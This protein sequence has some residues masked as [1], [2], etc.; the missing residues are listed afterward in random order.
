MG[1]VY[2][3]YNSLWIKYKDGEGEWKY[4]PSGLKRGQEREA[5]AALARI[6]ELVT[7]GVKVKV[8]GP[9]TVRRWAAI[10]LEHQ[11]KRDVQTAGDCE[12]RLRDHILP[13]IGHMRVDKVR[14]DDIAAIVETLKTKRK[15]R[16]KEDEKLAP[17]TVRNIY[18][19]AHALFKHAVRKELITSNP[20]KLEPDELPPKRD[21]YPEWRSTAIFTRSEVE[22]LLSV[23]SIPWWRRVFYALLFL[24][25]MRFGEAA[26]RRWRHYVADTAPL[27]RL[28][29]CTS[30]QSKK[31][32]EKLPKTEQTR[33]VPVHPTLATI[34]TAWKLGGWQR[35]MG[36]A[37]TDDD[38]I[39]PC[40]NHGNHLD[41]QAMLRQFHGDLIDLGYRARRQHDTRRTFISLCMDNGAR[42][43]ILKWVTHDHPRNDSFDDY[44]T[45]MWTG[46]CQEVAKLPIS[47]R[48]GSS[49]DATAAR[50]TGASD[51]ELVE[52]VTGRVT[53][54]E[55]SGG[56][57]NGSGQ[58]GSLRLERETGLGP[59]TLG[60]GS[61]CST[62]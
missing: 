45:L 34:L 15:S 28:V 23:E 16:R 39:V 48:Q 24:T 26:A 51:D 60:L 44:V 19:T 46:L 50:G 61:R 41:S 32:R 52:R 59:A 27:G 1:C 14:V 3:R 11:R 35:M 42:K 12:A 4:R 29:V 43:E 57:E 8:D 36:R 38:L 21:K 37:P 9:L 20:C 5:Q 56:I 53:G 25:G 62:N 30:Y 7:A 47:I 54:H 31:K 18:F 49:A 13:A 33:Y 55:A 40:V 2:P 10:W 22:A 17:K 6:E 58:V